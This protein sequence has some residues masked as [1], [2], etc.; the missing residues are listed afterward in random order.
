MKL[1]I[2]YE[3]TFQTLE[4]DLEEMWGM[5]CLTGE[6]HMSNQDREKLVQSMVDEQFNRPEYNNLHR[7]NRHCSAEA[8]PKRLDGRAAHVYRESSEELSGSDRIE[9]FPDEDWERSFYAGLDY[10][11]LVKRLYAALPSRQADLLLRVHVDGYRLSEIAAE[12]GISRS[13]VCQRLRTAE[14]N[15]RKMYPRP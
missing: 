9:L 3:S 15:I 8:A 6:D 1:R 2:R 14:K 13:A 11:D 7:F 5:L 10:E 4:V 12:E